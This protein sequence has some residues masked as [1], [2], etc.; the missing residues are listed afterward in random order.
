MILAKFDNTCVNWLLFS[1]FH[2]Q[3]VEGC[4]QWKNLPNNQ[5]SNRGHNL[6]CCRRWQGR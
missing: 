5:P 3:W 6:S 2:K 4:C 1:D